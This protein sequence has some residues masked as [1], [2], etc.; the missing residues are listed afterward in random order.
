MS[1]NK[2][3]LTGLLNGYINSKN[4]I[5]ESLAFERGGLLLQ[6]DDNNDEIKIKITKAFNKVL[7][8]Y[9]LKIIKSLDKEIKA[10]ND[11]LK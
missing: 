8:S 11:C 1:I 6:E 2:D 7:E 3:Y 4:L 5:L 9:S 10:L